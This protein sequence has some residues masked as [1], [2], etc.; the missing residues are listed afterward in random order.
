MVAEQGARE[1]DGG[2]LVGLGLG[3]GDDGVAECVGQVHAGEQCVYLVGEAGRK[4][5]TPD[6]EDVGGDAGLRQRH[7]CALPAGDAVRGVQGDGVPG[8]GDAPFLDAAFAEEGCCGV[9]AVDFESLVAVALLLIP[10]SCRTQ[11]RNSSSSS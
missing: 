11:L 2:C 10:M 8:D 4:V 9:G 3:L 1:G 7:L 6:S 5:L